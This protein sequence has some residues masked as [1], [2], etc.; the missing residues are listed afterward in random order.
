[1]TIPR[2][3]L[4]AAVVSVAISS[5]LKEELGFMNSDEYFWTDSKVV[6]G[7]I[8]NEARRFHTFV[9]NR[10]QKIHLTTTPQRWRYVPTD[11]NPADIA[12]RGSSVSELLTS[13][14]ITGPLFLWEKEIPPAEEVI[15]EIPVGDPEVK[16][17]LN[18]QT[19]EQVSLSDCLSRFSWYGIKSPKLSHASSVV[20]RVTNQ[21][22]TVLYRSE[23][24]QG[25]PYRIVDLQRQVYTEEIKLLSKGAQL[26]SKSK[27]YPLDVFLDEDGIL[28]V[29]GR[30]KNAC[31]PTSQ[32]HPMIIPKDH[33]ITR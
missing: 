14:W 32:K 13:D 17:S 3:E 19:T 30:L 20:P 4:T 5:I 25:V 1:M 22:D 2:L 27:L 18:V 15:T 26:L 31:L 33:H 8:N 10:I 29:G 23:R 16:R 7:Y 24:K 28:K 12:S 9:S 11:K 6:L 21:Q